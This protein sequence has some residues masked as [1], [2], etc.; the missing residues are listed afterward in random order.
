M[1]SRNHLLF[2]RLLAVEAARASSGPQRPSA[3]ARTKSVKEVH[4]DRASE[5][6]GGASR[7]EEEEEG[8]NVLRC[9]ADILGTTE[10]LVKKGEFLSRMTCRRDLTDGPRGANQHARSYVSVWRIRALSLRRVNAQ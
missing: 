6:T 8:L 7:E 5:V 4:G 1:I 3:T 9:R 2:C 10:H